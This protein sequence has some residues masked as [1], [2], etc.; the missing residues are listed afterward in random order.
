MNTWVKTL[1]LAATLAGFTVSEFA[2]AQVKPAATASS[3]FI[4]QGVS[5]RVATR[6]VR[7]VGGRVTH[8][9]PIIHGVSANLSA[10]Q[11]ARL[12][13]R[14]DLQ[15]FADA[16][17]KTQGSPIID[18]YARAFI[19]ADLLAAHGFYGNGVTVAVLDTG[20]WYSSSYVGKDL[21][22]NNKVLAMYDAIA[23]VVQSTPDGNGHGSHIA[24][25]I[26]S[27]KTSIDGKPLGKLCTGSIE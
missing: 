3:G 12:R 15:L 19:G 17:V 24:S 18:K 16:S 7:A 22:G 8:D 6:A 25:I 9:L 14:S 1:L 2:T 5:T 27:P 21:N 13:R 11:V 23:G 4:V 10:S 20:L 26:G